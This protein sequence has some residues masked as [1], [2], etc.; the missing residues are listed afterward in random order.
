MKRPDEWTIIKLLQWTTTYFKDQ[1]IASARIDAELLLAFV[2]GVERIDLYLRHDQ[3]LVT[4]ELT[5]YR[6]LVKRRA[7]REPVA[8]ITGT[9]G[10]W[11]LTL[12]VG[13]DV[14]IPRPET[15]CLVEAVL[16]FLKDDPGPD[17]PAFLDLG[18]GSGAIALAL[19]QSCPEASV[20]AVERSGGALAMADRN[21]LRNGLQDRVHLVA[22]DWLAPFDPL[23]A[24]FDVIVSN[25]PYIPAGDI[26]GL[27]PEITRYEP[28]AALD[29]G[30]EGL[31]CLDHIITAAPVF[32]RPGG[33]LFL[34]IGHDQFSAVRRLAEAGGLYR[35]AA[36]R[37]DYSGLD[38]VACL[39]R[40]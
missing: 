39:V 24:R 4:A 14:L 11:D 26:G 9:K 7:A 16:D 3:P 6:G 1:G 32:L 34:E 38:R 12:A 33:G 31:D 35:D 30:P 17:A 25:P 5:R 40:A 21:R 13:P 20:T 27:Q 2:L 15:E 37:K 36:C 18:T 23:N 22:G 10:F 29:G 28:R 19:A 8:Y